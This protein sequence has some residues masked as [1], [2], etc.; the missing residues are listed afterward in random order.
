MSKDLDTLASICTLSLR[1]VTKL[2]EDSRAKKL[3]PVS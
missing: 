3:S 1:G 2:T